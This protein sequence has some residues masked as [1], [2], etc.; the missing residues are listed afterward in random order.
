MSTDAPLAEQ[1][2]LVL[3]DRG[4]Q[5]MT[6]RVLTGFLFTE[7]P[8]LTMGDVGTQLGAST[9]SVSMSIKSLLTAGLVERVPADGRRDH[10]RLRD[11]AWE[12]LFT[13]QNDVLPDLI[14]IAGRAAQG[15]DPSSPAHQRLARMHGFY[16]FLQDELPALVERWQQQ[17]DG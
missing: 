13:S 10:F 6:A 11:D 1:M 16:Q 8:S 3:A 9:G 15:T 17:R 14:D 2:A 7:E 5:R 12:R 4:M